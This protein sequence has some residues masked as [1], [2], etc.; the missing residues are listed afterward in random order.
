MSA[1][2]ANA[3]LPEHCATGD[4][5]TCTT[6]ES[7]YVLN[8]GVCTEEIKIATT[9]MVDEEFKAA[10]E[11]LAETVDVVEEVVSN[12]IIQAGQIATLQAEKQTRPDE[13]CPAGKKC[14]LVTDENGTSHWHEMIEPAPAFN[15][16]EFLNQLINTD[17]SARYYAG[18]TTTYNELGYSGSAEIS[19][20]P[21]SSGL[22][23]LNET[24]WGVQ[25]NDKGV[26][27]GTS[28][29][30][31]NSGTFG[32][33]SPTEQTETKG[34]Y[35]WCK[36]TS[37]AGIDNVEHDVSGGSW[38]VSHGYNG[39]AFCANDCANQCAINVEIDPAFR[40]AVFGV[41]N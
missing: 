32:V 24:E 22:R 35:C 18:N 1:I 12:T 33:A 15:V 4:G 40:G 21:A 41:G 6:C 11:Q 13:S 3:A 20:P 14:L 8:N 39:A 25:W 7:G 30:N 28:V 31:G 23:Q 10:E 34:R 37:V 38:V 29:C 9:K 2:P 19:Q 36:M 16:V 26:V 27:Y 17:G 5:D